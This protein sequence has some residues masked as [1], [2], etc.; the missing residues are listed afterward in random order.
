MDERA[1]FAGS[2]RVEKGIVIKLGPIGVLLE[3]DM[4]FGKF[5]MKLRYGQVAMKILRYGTDREIRA[6]TPTRGPLN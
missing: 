1:K 3:G 6:D 5:A 4:N 2:D